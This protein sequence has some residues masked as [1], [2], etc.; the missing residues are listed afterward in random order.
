ML[1][2]AVTLNVMCIG[3]AHFVLRGNFEVQKQNRDSRDAVLFFFMR[4]SSMIHFC[5]LSHMNDCKKNLV[6]RIG[7]YVLALRMKLVLLNW[8]HHSGFRKKS[9][10]SKH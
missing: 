7:F 9:V 2:K 10:Y 8:I 4:W 5:V 3:P 6:L 1:V